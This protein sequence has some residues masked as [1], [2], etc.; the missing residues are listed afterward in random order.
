MSATPIFS[1]GL[2]GIVAGKTGLSDV[3]SDVDKLIYRGYDASALGMEAEFEE[4]AFMLLEGRLPN[5]GEIT[6]LKEKVHA[7]RPIEKPIA[8]LIQALP[9]KMHCMD[10][11]RTGVSATA[12][13]DPDVN[14][15]SKEANVR[16]ALRLMAKIPTILGV[17]QASLEGRPV[18]EPRADL[19]HAGNL[20]LAL[21]GRVP[22]EDEVAIMNCS[23]TL[24]AEHGYNASTFTARVCTSTLSD[25]HSSITGAIGTLKGPLHGGA[26]EAAMEMLEE[27]GTVENA[28]P[29][30]MDGLA[31]K[32]KIMGFGHRVYKKNDSRA[33]TL[34]AIGRKWAE[35]RGDTRYADM[36]DKVEEVM[37]REKN[38][39]PN[40]DFPC[41]WIYRMLG[42]P[43]ETYTPI[44]AAARV[45]GWSAHVIEQFENNR[46]IR[47]DQEYI[48]PHEVV[49]HPPA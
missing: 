38:L 39:F 37:R 27:I 20:L 28:E 41:A 35:K 42:L 46:L 25:L 32:A 4:T 44:F 7:A 31:R 49:Y 48:G 45:T 24:Y 29:W 17:R 22:D 2:D 30:I 19:N 15:N 47:P 8:D 23:L 3:R 33:V 11:L 26:N 34:R 6:D 5:R 21:T 9:E 43:I 16:K 10:V 18:P 14:D 36:A 13:W 12:G 1:P 40:V